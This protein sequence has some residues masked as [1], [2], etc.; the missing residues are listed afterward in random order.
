MADI[1]YRQ[2]TAKRSTRVVGSIAA[3][4]VVLG[5]LSAV[6]EGILV[7]HYDCAAG[8]FLWDISYQLA[9]VLS[10]FSS[11][12]RVLFVILVVYQIGRLLRTAKEGGKDAAAPAWS[13]RQSRPSARPAVR[14]AAF[15]KKP[16]AHREVDLFDDVDRPIL[17]PAEELESY[18]KRQARWEKK[19]ERDMS[20]KDAECEHFAS[21]DGTK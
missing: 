18:I 3:G 13:A 15:Q 14:T 2:D 21:G 5:I 8:T 20:R 10:A 1:S 12:V 17:A 4:V 6:T 19:L 7:W 16:A 9:Q 11:V